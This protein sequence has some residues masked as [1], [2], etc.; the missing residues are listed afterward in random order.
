MGSW[1]VIA[2][3]PTIIEKNV[4]NAIETYALNSDGTI[5]TTFTFN[6]GNANGAPK[7]Y[8]PTGFVKPGTGNAIWGMQFIWPIKA[9]YRIV[10]LDPE[11]KTTIIARNAR[12]YVWLMSRNPSMNDADYMGFI[13]Q[14]KKMGYDTNKLV[15]IP[16]ALESSLR[17]DAD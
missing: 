3:I 1:Y 4:H 5:G 15:K 10:Y 6:K 13:E 14:I 11:Y 12:D 8:H 16:Q 17:K 7:A 9:E 2:C